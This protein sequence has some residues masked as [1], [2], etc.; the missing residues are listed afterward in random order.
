MRRSR[1]STAYVGM[2][3][4]L[5]AL[6]A[7]GATQ[8]GVNSGMNHGSGGPS[9]IGWSLNYPG[10]AP[11]NSSWG[12]T[13]SGSIPPA[14]ENI[15]LT[16]ITVSPAF[17]QTLNFGWKVTENFLAKTYFSQNFSATANGVYTLMGVV[18]MNAGEIPIPYV[19]HR[20]NGTTDQGNLFILSEAANNFQNLFPATDQGPFHNAGYRVPDSERWEARAGGAGC[21]PSCSNVFMTFGPYMNINQGAGDYVADYHF[22]LTNQPATNVKIATI[23]AFYVNSLNQG[24]TLASRDLYKSDFPVAGTEYPFP[25]L[26]TLP[27]FVPSNSIQF[28]VRWTG[29][30]TIRQG[31]TKLYKKF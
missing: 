3:A 22:S 8:I 29:A 26:F 24:I 25:I 21:I 20:G 4:F 15:F 31:A 19:I 5:A 2:T 11:I 28:R 10:T 9:S 17:L 6:G 27:S 12:Y 13:S 7:A 1:K 23:D 16:Q 14:G 18:R 30:G